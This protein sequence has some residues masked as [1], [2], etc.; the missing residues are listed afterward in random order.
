MGSLDSPCNA[1]SKNLVFSLIFDAHT[2]KFSFE[3][4]RVRKAAEAAGAAEAEEVFLPPAEG[5]AYT[6]S[7]TG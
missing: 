4:A 6:S 1:T 2:A 7:N 5:V 3:S